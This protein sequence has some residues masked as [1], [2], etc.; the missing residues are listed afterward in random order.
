MRKYS[1]L[2]IFMLSADGKLNSKQRD[3]G[4]KGP[5]KA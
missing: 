3:A 1:R 4:K 2:L 5:E